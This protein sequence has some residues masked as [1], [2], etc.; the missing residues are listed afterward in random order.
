MSLVFGGIRAEG[1]GIKEALRT[2]HIEES[3][4]GECETLYNYLVHLLKEEGLNDEIDYIKDGFDG[5]IDELRRIAY[6]SDELL[7]AYQQEVMQHSKVPN[8]KVK[9]V[10]NQ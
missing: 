2:L 1:Q 9:Y 6:H 5:E 3:V 8:V 4:L 7:L 10:S